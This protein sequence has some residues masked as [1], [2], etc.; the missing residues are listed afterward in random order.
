MKAPSTNAIPLTIANKSR[1]KI[2]PI[3]CNQKVT[4]AKMKNKAQHLLP[5]EIEINDF[6]SV[7]TVQ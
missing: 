2:I 5:I 6:F 7:N 1:R 3:A 4:K